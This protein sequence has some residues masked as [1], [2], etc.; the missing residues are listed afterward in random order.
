M[1]SKLPPPSVSAPE[2]WSGE[3]PHTKELEMVG[4][5]L[6]SQK[7]PPPDTAVLLAIMQ[8]VMMGL[9]WLQ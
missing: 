5:L 4:L 1:Q 6:E 3:F 8:L 2:I 7:I 9:L